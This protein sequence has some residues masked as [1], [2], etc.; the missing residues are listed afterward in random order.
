[1]HLGLIDDR[2]SVDSERLELAFSVIYIGCGSGVLGIYAAIRGAIDADFIDIHH[3]SVWNT[4]KNLE[5]NGLSGRCHA[6]RDGRVSIDTL[7]GLARLMLLSP[8]SDVTFF[9]KT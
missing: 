9:G 6:V 3:C 7:L 8:M 2:S 5:L 4:E 1:M